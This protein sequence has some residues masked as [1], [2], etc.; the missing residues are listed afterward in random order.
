M[1]SVILGNDWMGALGITFNMFLFSVFFAGID[2]S[3]KRAGNSDMENLG[4]ITVRVFGVLLV[5]ILQ[6][7]FFF[8]TESGGFLVQARWEQ[9]LVVCLMAFALLFAIRYVMYWKGMQEKEEKNIEDCHSAT[10]NAGYL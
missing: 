2:G 8:A 7:I 9:I 10:G 6:L 4:R 1:V 5:V 3:L